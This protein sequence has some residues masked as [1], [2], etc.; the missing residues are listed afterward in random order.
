M[1]LS[2]RISQ[3]E[4]DFVEV[5]DSFPKLDYRWDIKSKAW[6]IS[7]E[8]DIC[9]VKGDY[10]NT[11]NIAVFVPQAYPYCVPH[12]FERSK[13]TPR[14]V[15]WHI[16]NEGLCCV[17]SDNAL[18]AS[19]RIGINIKKFIEE[20]VYSFFANQ[21]YKLIEDEYAG[22]EYKH[23]TEGVIQYYLEELNIPTPENI[24]IFLKKILNKRD[25][26]RNRICPC[27]SGEKIK[28]CHEKAIATIKSIGRGK[29]IKDFESIKK[30]L[31]SKEQV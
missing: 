6:I 16:S 22:A 23:H 31:N 29:I 26:T 14:D 19:S 1:D 21:L 7:G 30:H 15:D 25:L 20:K 12:V 10:W 17:D 9:D 2:K 3:F 18:L 11:F 5:K 27:N 13:I 8:L 24:L 4:R 28:N